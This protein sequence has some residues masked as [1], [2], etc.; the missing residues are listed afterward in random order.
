MLEN[1][2]YFYEA[3]FLSPIFLFIYWLCIS[4]TPITLKEA[5]FSEVFGGLEGISIILRMVEGG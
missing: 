5:K 3:T 1:S 2:H 4:C